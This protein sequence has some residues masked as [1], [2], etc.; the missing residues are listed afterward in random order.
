MSRWMILIAHFKNSLSGA[1]FYSF[2]AGPALFKGH[3]TMEKDKIAN[4][5]S[6]VFV[7]P[8]VLDSNLEPANIVDAINHLAN[9][10]MAI[11]NS[12]LDISCSIAN[13]GEKL[14][15]DTKP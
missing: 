9:A 5:I 3:R 2:R 8:N 6:S 1:G 4:A 7:S 10:N 14:E 13:L 15:K 12:L 11:S